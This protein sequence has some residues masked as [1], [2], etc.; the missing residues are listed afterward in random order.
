MGR[1]KIDLTGQRFGKLV[2]IRDVGRKN[3]HVLWECLCDCGEPLFIG[4]NAS[5]ERCLT[6]LKN[7]FFSVFV[8]ACVF[9]CNAMHTDKNPFFFSYM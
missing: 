7:P 8:D 3:G 9:K 4:E 5:I 2:V 1:K 6:R